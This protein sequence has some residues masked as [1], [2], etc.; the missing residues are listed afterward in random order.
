MHRIEPDALR[1]LLIVGQ[2]PQA[3]SHT[4]RRVLHAKRRGQGLIV[5][6]YQGQL[7]QYL[8]LHNKGN[9]QNGPVLWCDLGQRRR[10]WSLPLWQRSAGLGK[11]LMGL[12]T[13][14]TEVSGSHVPAHVLGV[15]TQLGERLAR[16]GGFGLL[17]LAR[18]LSRPELIQGTGL[19]PADHVHVAR[20]VA[21][22]R[23]CLGFGGVWA[24]SEGPNV[25][26]IRETLVR[27]GTVWIELPTNG[28]EAAEHALMARLLEAHLADL[29]L[30]TGTVDPAEA[31]AEPELAAPILLHAF[32]PGVPLSFTLAPMRAMHIMLAGLR[33]NNKALPRAAGAWLERSC[34]CWAIGPGTAMEPL[35]SALKLDEAER[36]R[37]ASVH[38]DQLWVRAG[39]GG[40]G[41]TYQMRAVEHVPRMA[42]EYRR[43]ALVKLRRPAEP[44]MSS[45]AAQHLNQSAAVA[46]EAV[47]AM[48]ASLC[49]PA[50]LMAG[51]FKV[52]GHNP[53]SCGVDGITIKRFG[54]ELDAH[55]DQLSS[56]LSAGRYRARALRS[57]FIPKQDGDVRELRIACV[58]DR[59]VQAAFLMAVEGLFEP[60][61][62]VRSFGYRPGRNAHQALAM[63]RSALRQGKTYAVV[64]DIRKCFD[65][66]DH[67]VLLRLVG[68][69]LKDAAMLGLL[70]HWLMADVISFGQIQ[71]I[72]VGVPQ[73]ESISP[74]LCNIYLD[75]LDRRFEQEGLCFV[76]YADDYL[77]LCESV[78]QSEAALGLMRTVLGEH[79]HLELKQNKTQLCDMR[80]G[81]RFLGFDLSTS[82]VRIPADKCDDII[83]RALP[84][85]QRAVDAGCSTAEQSDARH[86]L[87]ALT[88]GFRNYYAVD[89][90]GEIPRQLL[91]LDHRLAAELVIAPQSEPLW[92][93]RQRFGRL[94][95]CGEAD[96][97]IELWAAANG[98]YGFDAVSAAA[99]PTPKAEVAL[100]APV[101]A[102]D[103][104]DADT[105]L[106]QNRRLHVLGGP[107]YV[108]VRSGVLSVRRGHRELNRAE[109]G[110]LDLIYL[111]GRR[112]AI[113]TDALDHL[114]NL[115][116]P[117]VVASG[118][119]M[120]C[121]V[122]GGGRAESARWRQLQVLRRDDPQ[123]LRSGLD[124]LAA[125]VANQAS[126][127]RYF[128]RY[129][130][131][132]APEEAER[133]CATANDIRRASERL[134]TL[135]TATA[136]LRAVAMGHEGHAAAQYWRAVASLLPD[137][138]RFEG[139]RTR[140]A[141]DPF[142][143]CLNYVYGLLYGEVWRCVVRAGLD[144]HFGI[145]HGTDADQGSLVFDLIEELRAPLADR[146][147]LGLVGRGFNI[148]MDAEGSLGRPV[149]RRLA[150]TFYRQW[151]RPVRAFGSA[152]KPRELLERQV[153]GLRASLEGKVTYTAFRFRW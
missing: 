96:E 44:Q 47:G 101:L 36:T 72:E 152:L 11:C 38:D 56:E 46:P 114:T 76:R 124:M 100:A 141:A 37:L 133:L 66:I 136:K 40:R 142:N 103:A 53:S 146:L 131:R 16:S 138:L 153:L 125:K 140:N 43:L 90:P 139:R 87:D 61:F 41:A 62:S 80:E 75:L 4:L 14:L 110:S 1:P 58:R 55:I 102:G 88:Q 60:H 143:A 81:T 78:A 118:Y 132:V 5:V 69:V 150:E 127:L 77:V 122:A 109:I 134:D 92:D 95:G 8:H 3:H 19:A 151:E 117:V 119:G 93:A 107:C 121:A 42:E 112:I 35:A 135:D 82:G 98:L 24:I 91:E 21:H 45:V 10:P 137:C 15:A 113:L 115:G 30:G 105:I 7:G 111:E 2:A 48:F 89:D 128:A 49:E 70:R 13:A 50:M 85:A 31:Q 71:P 34:D 108:T 32:P 9:L 59:V 83:E 120:P 74:L 94:P 64:A 27:G 33:D 65:S 145:L 79:L 126:V 25:A 22:L 18:A 149:R 67:E 130:K 51:W 63:A 29:L 57:A 73:G 144:P 68:D 54:K 17:G 129:R 84:L 147:V 86:R 26:P 106:L 104:S 20:L 28:L 99:A 6:D 39:R 52:K 116:V 148:A 12:L 23:W 97:L 123:Q